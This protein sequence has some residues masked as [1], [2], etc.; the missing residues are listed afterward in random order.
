MR[1]RRAVLGV[2]ATLAMLAVAAPAVADPVTR[3]EMPFPCGE[4]WTGTTRSSHSPSS[5][6]ID[7][8]SPGDLG[9]PV[10]ASAPG[11]VLTA[12]NI[13][14]SGYGR[15]VMIDHGN[16][17]RSLYAHLSS[18]NV[19]AGQRVDQGQQI[20]RLGSTGNSTGPHLHFEERSGSSVLWPFLHRSKFKFGTTPTSMNCVEVPLAVD[21]NGDKVA[22]PTVFRRDDPALFRIYR[23]GKSPVVKPFGGPEDDPVAGD[24]DGNGTMNFGVRTPATQTFTMRTPKGTTTLRFGLATDKPIAGDW[25]GDRKW[26]PGLWRPSEHQFV[27]RH[28][29]GSVDRV[30]FGD[31][32]DLP[33]V[34]D[35]DGDRKTDLGVFDQA[36]ATFTLRRV[37]DD[38]T[39]WFAKVK[40]GKPGDL[41][42]VA[43]WDGNGR[44]DLAVWNPVTG[45]FTQR[46]AASTS[47][48]MRGT[49]SITF[50]RRR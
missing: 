36:T 47:A 10:V 18:L 14:N 26:T 15:W 28:T 43:D 33:V 45:V 12:D 41:P 24:W 25:D 8:N 50:G 20:G 22:E 34:G 17:E 4:K 6:A 3:F 2:V 35:W 23:G 13:N 9:K 21:W 11:V 5:R 30:Y 31:A 49:A 44:A 16:N 19:T 46:K 42:A 29:D 1:V 32:N 7:W 37:D 40:F 27:L 38:G 48:T 39:E